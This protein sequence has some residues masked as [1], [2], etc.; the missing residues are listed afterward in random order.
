MNPLLINFPVSLVNHPLPEFHITTVS[1]CDPTLKFPTLTS[2]C[3]YPQFCSTIPILTRVPILSL[4]NYVCCH[5]AASIS[6]D[7]SSLYVPHPCPC[8]WVPYD[9]ANMSPAVDTS[10]STAHAQMYT[11]HNKTTIQPQLC[12][13]L[14]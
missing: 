12:R 2:T 7:T 11:I 10:Q 14:G 6:H 5:L 3:N 13:Q 4:D 9:A 8:H 1:L